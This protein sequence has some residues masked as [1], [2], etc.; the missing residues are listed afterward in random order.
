MREEIP[1]DLQL[2]S[3]QKYTCHSSNLRRRL[4][5]ART[6]TFANILEQRQLVRR[7]GALSK[8]RRR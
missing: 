5:L 8:Q 4:D 7:A 2:G 6:A 1:T 3:M